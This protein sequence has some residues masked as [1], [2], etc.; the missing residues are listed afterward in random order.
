MR[1]VKDSNVELYFDSPPIS[2][3]KGQVYILHIIDNTTKKLIPIPS[4]LPPST[5][6][7]G[8]LEREEAKNGA[9]RE[10]KTS[11]VSKNLGGLVGIIA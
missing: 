4:I 9:F 11:E 3:H 2:A 7:L 5:G 6:A 10:F 8:R 1:D